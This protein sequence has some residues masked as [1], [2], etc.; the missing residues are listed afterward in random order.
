MAYDA[1][2]VVLQRCQKFYLLV[3][4]FLALLFCRLLWSDL[5]EVVSVMERDP[6]CSIDNLY[7]ECESRFLETIGAELSKEWKEV[8]K[9]QLYE[10]S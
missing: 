3:F 9:Q 10:A 8:D 6:C 7:G 1:K 5:S 4:L 2:I